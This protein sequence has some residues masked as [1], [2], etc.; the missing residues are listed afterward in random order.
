MTL[1]TPDQIRSRQTAYLATEHW[2]RSRVEE[3]ER[4]LSFSSER[5]FTRQ[6]D[7]MDPEDRGQAGGMGYAFNQAASELRALLAERNPR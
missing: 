3:L 2:W 1:P 4:R 5:A 6:A 7:L